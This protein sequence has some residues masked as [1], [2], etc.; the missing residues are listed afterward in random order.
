M[1]RGITLGTLVVLVGCSNLL[2][3]QPPHEASDGG[4]GGIDGPAADFTIQLAHAT[5]RVPAG[6]FDFIDVIVS[7]GAGEAGPI[8]V[9][10][11]QP[12]PGV[13]SMAGTI[14]ANATTGQVRI[15]GDTSL[16]IGSTLAVD[17]VASGG[18]FS[19]DAEVDTTVTGIP[20]TLDTTFGGTNTGF[21]DI[22]LGS[23]AGT[24]TG[25]AVDAGGQPIA[26]GT[27]ANSI[28]DTAQITVLH[29]DGT[30][31]VSTTSNP[32]GC[33]AGS[34]FTTVAVG[35]TG[36]LFAIGQSFDKS[37]STPEFEPLVEG[38]TSAGVLDTGFAGTGTEFIDL[39]ADQIMTSIAVDAPNLLGIS[40]AGLLFRITANGSKIDL[41]W[42]GG[43]ALP[44]QISAPGPQAIAV[45]TAQHIY[46]VGQGSG[47]AALERIAEQGA[48]DVAF[49]TNGIVDS[50]VAGTALVAT[51]QADHGI[52]VAGI[53]GGNFLLFRVLASGALDPAFG[54]AGVSQPALSFTGIA[55]TGIAIQADGK[56]ILAGNSGGN[57]IL[58]RYLP[59]GAIDPT[60][61]TGG[62]ASIPAGLMP[63][64][65]GVAVQSSG[66][67]VL[68]GG[69]ADQPHSNGVDGNGFVARVWF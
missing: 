4:G 52:L 23:L 6:G 28:S 66:M 29:P 14:A 41:N 20:G 47:N 15:T 46:V 32:C 67:I 19:H 25:L 35:N 65:G 5:A 1:L 39:G 38:F 12:P 21:I 69:N 22:P 48:I 40:S 59:N 55:M 64:M 11:P 53:A 50:G 51:V 3:L 43:E 45:D 17:V 27:V 30:L 60:F 34:T 37:L 42:N 56:I 13:T 61:G 36:R 16:T 62:A 63:V 57:A 8:T 2:G 10:V 68:D 58:A 33:S 49:G 24:F 44:V 9:D 31:L 26:V 54:T 18:G 7:R